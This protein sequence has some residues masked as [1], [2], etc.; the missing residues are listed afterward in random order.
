M[1]KVKK[2][3]AV[4]DHFIH[5]PQIFPFPKSFC[6]FFIIY[7]EGKKTHTHTISGMVKPKSN[8]KSIQWELVEFFGV[9]EAIY[10][11]FNGRYFGK[12]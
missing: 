1:E 10:Q 7:F 12:L 11:I 9:K 2:T 8:S 3:R 5:L 4:T 6:T